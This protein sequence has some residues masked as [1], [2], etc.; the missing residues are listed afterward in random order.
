M[1]TDVNG[2]L[3]N[4]SQ[5]SDGVVS[6]YKEINEVQTAFNHRLVDLDGELKKQLESATKDM[7]SKYDTISPSAKKVFDASVVDSKKELDKLIAELKSA[8]KKSTDKTS[9]IEN[10]NIGL[11]N[12]LSKQNPELNDKEETLKVE[13]LKTADECKILGKQLA[14]YDG[15]KG[16]FAGSSVVALRKTFNEKM[17]KLEALNTQINF[18]RKTWSERLTD[19]EKTENTDRTEW[20]SLQKDISTNSMELANI[21]KNYEALSFQN[22]ITTISKGVIPEGFSPECASALKKIKELRA[23][24]EELIS[25]LIEI[26]GT[27]ATLKGLNDGY[28]AFAKSVVNLKHEQDTYSTLAKLNF[29]ISDS[30]SLLNNSF[31]EIIPTIKDEK[32]MAENP[33]LYSESI[34]AKLSQNLTDAN[35]EAMF[36]SLGKA[37]EVATKA[38]K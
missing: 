36:N 12:D 4:I 30:V 20:M 32:K 22:A 26:S 9:A 25:G 18:L 8:I 16:W 35:I 14:K 33:K 7:K 37:V 28:A 29:E 5:W 17:K 38:W 2:F 34:K 1:R 3:K 13:I 21:E 6:L 31:S 23:A 24:K 27:L 10:K 19:S 15:I 11:H